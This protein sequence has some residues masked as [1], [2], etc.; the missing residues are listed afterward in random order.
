M[1]SLRYT[2]LI[3]GALIALFPFYWMAIT[4]LSSHSWISSIY[5]LP[6]PMVLDSFRDVLTNHPFARWTFNSF[7]VAGVGS[8]GNVFI[9]ALAAFSFACLDFKGNK[10]IFYIMLSVLA[11]P[12]FLLVI[13]RFLLIGGFGWI[14]TYQGVFVLWF[15]QMFSVFLLRQYFLGIPDESMEAARID[16]ASLWQIFWKIIVPLG[17]PALIALAVITFLRNW[18]SLL[19]PLVILNKISMQTLSVGMSGFAD[20]YQADFG[21]IMAGSMLS[22]IPIFILFIFLQ[23]NIESGIRIQIRR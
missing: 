7:V 16:G 15:F 12:G 6:N 11:L 18:N 22:L 8:I 20:F 23:K 19:W 2:I 13:P 10:T 17:K 9:S 1:K 3:V 14:N 4:A 21:N 5:F